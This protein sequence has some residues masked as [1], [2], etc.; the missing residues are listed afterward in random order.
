M[1][2]NNWNR[3]QIEIE[4]VWIT[5]PF[6]KDVMKNVAWNVRVIESK[7]LTKSLVIWDELIVLNFFAGRAKF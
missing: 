1:K 5:G 6:S 3:K 2:V 4:N 7:I